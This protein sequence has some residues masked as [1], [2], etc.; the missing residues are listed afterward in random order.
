MMIRYISAIGLLLSAITL[1]AQN[2]GINISNPAADLHIGGGDN[3]DA[4]LF[5]NGKAKFRHHY[6]FFVTNRAWMNV[7]LDADDNGNSDKF[8]LYHHTNTSVGHTPRVNLEIDEGS[9]WF[10]LGGNFGLG[11]QSPNDFFHMKVPG[12]HANPFRIQLNNA[13]K[14]KLASNGGVVIGSNVTGVPANGLYVDGKVGL[15]V[16]NPTEKLEVNGAIKI[17]QVQGSLQP[18]LIEYFGGE[19][20]G[21]NGVFWQSFTE[22]DDADAN[23]S[24]ELQTLSYN[25]VTNELSILQG[26][27]ISLPTPGSLLTING[28][29]TYKFEHTPFG[30]ARMAI[31]PND[32]GFSSNIFIGKGAG[33]LTQVTHPIS[34]PSGTG[35]IFIGE[36]AGQLNRTGASNVAIGQNAG[37][38]LDSLSSNTFVGNGAGRM[39]TGSLNTYLGASAGLFSTSGTSNVFL[40]QQAGLNSDDA[41]Y[42][43]FVGPVAG[44]NSD[45]NWNISIGMFAGKESDGEYNTII[46]SLAGEEL[47]T[48]SNNT[49]IGA[50][51]EPAS[52]NE[53]NRV[54]IANGLGELAFH[55]ILDI[56]FIVNGDLRPNEDGVRNLGLST[57][58]WNTIYLENPP[59]VVSD[60]RLKRNVNQISYGLESL[61]QLRPVNYELIANEDDDPKFGFIAQEVKEVIPELVELHQPEVGDLNAKPEHYSM[62]YT[63]LIPVLVKAVQEQQIMIEQKN[64]M[65]SE[66]EERL[67]RME[68]HISELQKSMLKKEK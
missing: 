29:L 15:G 44:M 55:A 3:T 43:V 7:F 28:M 36:N 35:N 12:G 67:Q 30:N 10:D 46:G 61:M 59:D 5:D 19:F 50:K 25:S 24:N 18:G 21:F 17:G 26:N 65:L 32:A 4:I 60:L 23:P 1:P 8:S 63:E 27:T 39:T 49:Y 52:S 42:N 66:Q 14:F 16:Q 11:T 40:G 6:D 13:T 47:L 53:S 48:G 68:R 38:S 41:S 31:F 54:R 58:R 34:P 2:V 37:M 64:Q 9:S 51:V 62:S 57:R 33:Q 20:Q 56:W 45:G 22:R